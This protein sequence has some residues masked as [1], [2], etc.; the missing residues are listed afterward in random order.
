M[1]IMVGVCLSLYMPA[2]VSGSA[3]DQQYPPCVIA[4]FE[5]GIEAVSSHQGCSISFSREGHGINSGACMVVQNESFGSPQFNFTSPKHVTYNLSVWIK[6]E[7]TPLT[8]NLQFLIYTYKE[9]AD[10]W[11]YNT[12]T[13]NE[14]GFKQG[15][16]VKVSAPFYYDGTGRQAGVGQFEGSDISFLQL[17]IGDGSMESIT[18]EESF[19]YY[20]DDMLIVPTPNHAKVTEDNMITNGDFENEAYLESWVY[21]KRICT[22]EKISGAAGTDSAVQISITGDYG[23]LI[24]KNIDLRFG[25]RYNISFYA[26][27]ISQEAIDSEFCMILSRIETKQDPNI[28]NYEY[29]YTDSGLSA[30]WKKYEIPYYQPLSTEDTCKADISFRV[31]SG[32]E[33]VTY[34]IDKVEICEVTNEYNILFS[35]KEHLDADGTLHLTLNGYHNCC[36]F[37]YQIIENSRNGDIILESGTAANKETIQWKS[38]INKRIDIIPIDSYG[39]VGALKSFYGLEHTQE[40]SFGVRFLTNAWT[41]DTQKITVN[42][43]NNS[44]SQVKTVQGILAQYDENGSLAAVQNHRLSFTNVGDEYVLDFI[45][46][47]NGVVAKFFLWNTISDIQPLKNEKTIYKC[48]GRYIYVDEQ[49]GSDSCA[50]TVDDPLKSFAGAKNKVAQLLSQECKENIYVIFRDGDYFIEEP[51]VFDSGDGSKD[52]KICYM[53]ENAGK[54]VITGGKQVSGFQM[55]DEPSGI[56]R[57]Y[58]GKNVMSRQFFVNGIRAVRA[59]SAGV[60]RDAVNIGH[61][62]TTSDLSLLKYQNISDL[63][64]VFYEKWTN[65][66]C[67]VESIRQDGNKAVLSMKQPAWNYVTGKGTTSATIPVWYENAYELIDEG[68]EWYL[69]SEEGYIYYKPRE[70]ENLDQAKCILPITEKLMIMTNSVSQIYTDKNIQFK[71]LAFSYTTWNYPTTTGGLSDAQNNLLRELGSGL[72]GDRLCD[73]AIEI[74]YSGNIRFEDCTFS[75]LGIIGIKLTEGAKKIDIIGCEFSD[76]S[77]SAI[78]VGESSTSNKDYYNPSSSR[79]YV[80]DINI[81]NNCIYSVGVEYQSSSAISVGFPKNC[82]ISHNEIYD[83]PYSGIHVG[84]GWGSLE[85]SGSYGIEITDN[86]IHNIMNSKLYD[87]GAI[88]TNGLTGAS[89]EDMNKICRNYIQNQKMSTGAIYN[90]EGSSFWQ[91]SENVIDLSEN[92]IWIMRNSDGSGYISAPTAIFMN[93]VSAKNNKYFNNYATTDYAIFGKNGSITEAPLAFSCNEWPAEANL[94]IK[95]AGIT[96]KYRDN[97]TNK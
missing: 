45:A 92:S 3:S 51:L 65:P 48:I 86:Y 44:L 21:D 7:K 79:Q 9:D 89:V 63:E 80:S 31:N 91:V 72:D 87:G 6:T 93:T 88:Y 15:E 12:V 68:G 32:L 41:D 43:K 50:G 55:Y 62:I 42:V 16:W 58:V 23:T 94:I 53:A 76:I 8:D 13:V 49:N 67:S 75:K 2:V 61:G 17:R 64:L 34:A 59:K 73:G 24:Q 83:I 37:A 26:K 4:D 54:S 77:G 39:G 97:F 90:D 1:L 69:D 96:E 57:A 81:N 38:G 30:E 47:K 84:L 19:T 78:A 28:M 29:L 52:L 10:D 27:A 40:D 60:L 46:D 95:K 22:A 11:L 56:Y 74:N 5:A 14:V 85:S 70:G 18:D 35:G 25:R 20:I 71:G 36:T 66:R 82:I 33:K